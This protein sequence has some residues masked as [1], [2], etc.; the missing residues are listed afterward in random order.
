MND[1]KWYW[2]TNEE[3]YNGPFETRDGAIYEGLSE[4]NDKIFIV[5]ARKDNINLSEEFRIKTWLYE[6]EDSLYSDDRGG[7]PNGSGHFSKLTD[8]QV[9]DL[10]SSVRKA[11]SEWQSRHKLVFDPWFF[12]EQRNEEVVSRDQT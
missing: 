9:E 7:D 10:Q 6:V 11:I 12:T 4:D 1:W 8:D 5:E 3:N 2:G